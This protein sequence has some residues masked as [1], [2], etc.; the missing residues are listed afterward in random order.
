[1]AA[2]NRFMTAVA[3][4]LCACLMTSASAGRVLLDRAGA[5]H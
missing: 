2:L 4:V 5:F 1:M 3:L